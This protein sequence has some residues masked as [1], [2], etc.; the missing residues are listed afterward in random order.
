MIPRLEDVSLGQ[1]IGI[2]FVIIVIALFMLALVGFLSGG[3]DEAKGDQVIIMLPPSKWDEKMDEL[4]RQALDEAYV[5]KVKQLFD[6]WVREGLTSSE[7]PA[8]GHAQARRAYISAH[9]AIEKREE[10]RRERK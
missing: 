4:D 1:R 9:E 6:V 3:W 8:K 7:G 10:L 2:T 5:A